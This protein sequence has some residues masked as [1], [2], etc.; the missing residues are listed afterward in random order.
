MD[1]K[2]R[3]NREEEETMV[4]KYLAIVVTVALIGMLFLL[5]MIADNGRYSIQ[6]SPW[7]VVTYML[8]TRSG[9]VWLVAGGQLTKQRGGPEVGSN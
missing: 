2:N 8:D 6:L 5:S 9:E 3:I 4:Q 7:S 1:G